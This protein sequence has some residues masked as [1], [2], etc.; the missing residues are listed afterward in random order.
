MVGKFFLSARQPNH[1][2]AARR[3]AR[4]YHNLCLMRNHGLTG[5]PHYIAR[6]LGC[7][8]SMNCLLVVE[9]C[10]G[11]LLS[12]MIFNAIHARDEG[13]LFYKMTALA[14]FLSSFHKFAKVLSR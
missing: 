9:H 6:P 11:E 5:C 10:D 8:Y 13:F 14:Y 12:N 2:K 3:L 7:N 1:E 4:E